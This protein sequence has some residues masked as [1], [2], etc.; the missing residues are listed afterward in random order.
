MDITSV[1]TIKQYR[2]L[3]DDLCLKWNIWNYM[4]FT[5]STS[6]KKNVKNVSEHGISDFKISYVK[7]VFR[8]L[9]TQVVFVALQKVRRYFY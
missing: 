5:K 6:E 2:D 3:E 9:S 7:M 4:D 8:R 1:N